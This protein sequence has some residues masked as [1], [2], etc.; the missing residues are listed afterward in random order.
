MISNTVE[1]CCAV[2]IYCKTMPWKV[3]VLLGSAALVNNDDH[4]YRLY[5]PITLQAADFSKSQKG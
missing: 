4:R 5:I 2:V 1:N 3:F